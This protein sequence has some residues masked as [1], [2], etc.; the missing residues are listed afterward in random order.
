[1]IKQ[2]FIRFTKK[3]GL[4]V[5]FLTSLFALTGCPYSSSYKIDDEPSVL[6]E[7]FFVGKW[8]SIVKGADGLDRPVKM[9]VDKLNEYEYNL[10]FTGNIQALTNYN[11][12]KEDTIKATAFVSETVSRRFLNIKIKGQYYISEFI[13]KDDKI[14]ILPLCEHFTVKLIKNNTELKQALELHYQMR[15]YPLYD[16]EFCLKEMTRVN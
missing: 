2:Q 3:I 14:T 12:I 6:T 16:E 7:D 11:I 4:L 9:I 8:A 10:N 5:I 15:R 1:M 13:Y